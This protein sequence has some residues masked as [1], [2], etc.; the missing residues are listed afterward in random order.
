MNKYLQSTHWKL[1]FSFLL[2]LESNITVSP[3]QTCGSR[4]CVTHICLLLALIFRLVFLHM[5]TT[6]TCEWTH[7]F[8]WR[9]ACSFEAKCWVCLVSNMFCWVEWAD[10]LP[11]VRFLPQLAQVGAVFLQRFADCLSA[12]KGFS[13]LPCC[14]SRSVPDTE[15]LLARQ[16]AVCALRWAFKVH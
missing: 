8:T 3:V 16:S 9:H 10:W 5:V 13:L 15:R 6:Q 14:M 4:A 2:Q 11:T 12:M 7:T 1:F